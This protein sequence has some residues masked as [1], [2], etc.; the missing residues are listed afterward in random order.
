MSGEL[1]Q[2]EIEE[3]K[4]Q[5]LRE[6][7]MLHFQKEYRELESGRKTSLNSILKQLNPFIDEDGLL[8]CDS[9]IQNADYL[10]FDTR[11][12]VILDKNSW[13]TKLLVNY[14]HILGNHECGTN[15]I[16]SM[17]AEHFWVLKARQDH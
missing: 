15:H 17:L 10:P 5:I 8:R 6:T 3:A 4:V 14:Y 2:F 16:L 11:Y 9:R 1:S 13:I 12:P 7:Q